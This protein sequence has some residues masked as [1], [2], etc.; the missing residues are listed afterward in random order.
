MYSAT[1]EDGT[2]RWLYAV[3]VEHRIPHRV[4]SGI[5]EQYVA[6]AASAG[7]PRRLVAEVATRTASLWTVPLSD[8]LQT[9]TDVQPF[10]VRNARAL[11]PRFASGQVLFLS[12]PG[13][14]DALWKLEKDVATELW[15]SS[16]SGV[17]APPAVS[18]DGRSICIAYRKRGRGGLYVMNANGANV[19]ALAESELFDVRSGPSWSPDGKQVAVTADA[20]EGMRVF[21]VPVDGGPPVQLVKTLSLNPEWSPDDSFILYLEQ[22]LG[23][24]FKLKAVRPDG[25]PFPIPDIDF[26]SVA[27]PPPNR[28][29]S[30]GKAAITLEVINR[31]PT[32][33]LEGFV[34]IDLSTGQ[35]RQLTEWRMGSGVQNFDISPDGK[36]IIF[37]RVRLNS[38][39]VMIELP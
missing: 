37:D 3:D 7:R 2:G 34:L 28:L 38:D 21:K 12:S 35:K 14:R 4:R 36:Q 29:I 27:A 33:A 11:A 10:A 26:Q 31:S 17:I 30:G 24:A 5:A 6:V 9:E 25:L 1:A 32:I 22:Q 19:R 15:A 13:G 23:A 16:E 18:P 8:R 20:G 39:I